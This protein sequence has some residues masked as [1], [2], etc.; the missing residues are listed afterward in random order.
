MH[1]TVGDLSQEERVRFRALIETTFPE[2]GTDE[3]LNGGD[4]LQRLTD[5]M[6]VFD[7]LGVKTAG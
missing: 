5:L 6:E 4:A 3:D 2:L 1:I 7:E